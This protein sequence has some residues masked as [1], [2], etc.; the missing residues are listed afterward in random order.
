MLYQNFPVLNFWHIA[1]VC[2]SGTRSNMRFE[3]AS[4]YEKQIV[5]RFAQVRLC[6]F[7][8]SMPHGYALHTAKM[9]M[10]HHIQLG[11]C[12]S[13]G[14]T[15]TPSRCILSLLLPFEQMRGPVREHCCCRFGVLRRI[16]CV[17]ALPS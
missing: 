16:Y 15:D 6:L 12:S 14:C 1:L 3:S 9:Q 5:T 13:C 10:D 4:E 7:R 17:T 2:I 11:S 8:S